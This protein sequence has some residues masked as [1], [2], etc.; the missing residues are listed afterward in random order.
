MGLD[1]VDIGLPH[2]RTAED[3]GDDVVIAVQLVDEGNHALRQFE[4][5]VPVIMSNV[6]V[7][8]HETPSISISGVARNLRPNL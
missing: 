3:G 5:L 6:C 2:Q 4:A 8:S 1:D 7:R